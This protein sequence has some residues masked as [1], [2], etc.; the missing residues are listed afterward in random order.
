MAGH[1]D[2]LRAGE[3][4]GTGDDLLAE[5]PEARAGQQGRVNQRGGMRK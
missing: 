1:G 4:G 3:G 2:D 5:T